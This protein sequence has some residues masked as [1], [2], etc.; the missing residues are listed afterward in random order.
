MTEKN[1]L[2]YFHTREEAEKALK[3]MKSLQ[4][5]DSSI[6]HIDKYPGDGNEVRMNPVTGDFASLGNLTLNADF[7]NKS[8]AIL[9]VAGVD[10]SG[11]SDGGQDGPTGVDTLLTV[12]IAEADHEQALQIVEMLGGQI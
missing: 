1:I 12:V 7:T 3:S 2:A 8:A 5:I 6:D 10:A 9:S 4:I 11:M